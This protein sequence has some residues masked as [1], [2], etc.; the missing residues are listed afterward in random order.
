M[1]H[2]PSSLALG[3]HGSW[4]ALALA[5]ALGAAGVALFG[6]LAM[7]GATD[8]VS[9]TLARS[10][11]MTVV[12]AAVVLLRGKGFAPNVGG[13]GWVWLWIVLA[14][15]C[16]AVS[17]LAY[18][19]AL[20]VGPVTGVAV[21]DRGSVVFAVLL[22]VAFLGERPGGRAWLGL[23]LV[24]AGLILV[25]TASSAPTPVTPALPA[26]QADAEPD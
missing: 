13:G 10:I 15:V 24:A 25:A 23:A 20:R 22:A 3:T 11:I 16:G 12:L 5:A 21:I 6:K 1:R 18:F 4:V 9:A 7:Q 26:G 2:F 17:W 14:G 19:G 8:T